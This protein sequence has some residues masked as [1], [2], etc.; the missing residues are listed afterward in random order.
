M[1]EY[2]CVHTHIHTSPAEWNPCNLTHS[3]ISQTYLNKEVI[4]CR[5][6]LTVGR[7][8]NLI[9]HC[10]EKIW[11]RLYYDELNKD[12]F[13]FNLL[14]QYFWKTNPRTSWGVWEIADSKSSPQMNWIKI[15]GVVGSRNL[16]F[17]TAFQVTFMHSKTWSYYS[18]RLGSNLKITFNPLVAL[19]SMLV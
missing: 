19:K 1:Y 6:P 11:M 17:K 7:G 14:T 16:H 18:I 4:F 15:A 12:T 9:P 13:L 8:R 3:S 10:V 2:I 5:I